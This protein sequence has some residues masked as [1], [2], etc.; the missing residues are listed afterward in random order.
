MKLCILGDCNFGARGDS[1]DFH[2][3]F[4]KFLNKEGEIEDGILLK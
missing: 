2:N 4:E 1:V 3:F